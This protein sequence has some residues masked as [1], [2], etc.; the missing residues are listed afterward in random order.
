MR[1]FLL[2]A[3]FV[4]KG[5]FAQPI[6]LVP[7]PSFEI[8]DTCPFNIVN[9]LYSGTNSICK[10]TP[11]FQPNRPQIACSG[12]SDFYHSCSGTVPSSIYGYQFAKTGLGYAGF[13]PTDNPNSKYGECI[14]VPLIQNLKRKKYCTSFYI[15]TPNI[16]MSSTNCIQARFTKDSVLNTSWDR[17]YLS[18]GIGATEI[19][20]DTV[21]WV[22]VKGIYDAKG[23]EK[24][25]TVG[26]FEDIT[27]DD[28]LCSE[29]QG[30]GFSYYYFDD[31]GVY[32]LPEISAG[33][34]G[35]IDTLGENIPL[36][37][38]CEGCWNDLV[39]RWWPSAGLSDTTILNPIATP[40]VTT[41]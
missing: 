33:L 17:I 34:G 18:D 40:E 12:S 9:P 2:L 39:Y 3:V 24:F 8:Y 5:I 28:Y 26:C 30:C 23:E 32:E 36:Q 11:W 10:A 15:N 21:N 14:E 35:E 4:C 13:G 22:L 20:R 25:M 31:F 38:S 27:W 41:T 6:N 7:N 16:E 29:T 37:A 19:V 1:F